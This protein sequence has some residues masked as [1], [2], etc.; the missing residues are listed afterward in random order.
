MFFARAKTWAWRL[1]TGPGEEGSGGNVLPVLLGVGL[2]LRLF[3]PLGRDGLGPMEIYQIVLGR[4]I[5][6]GRAW[7]DDLVFAHHGPVTPVVLRLWTSIG[8]FFASDGGVR[9]VSVLISMVLIAGVYVWLR[10]SAGEWAGRFAA[11]FLCVNDLVVDF[12]RDA[13]LYSLHALLVTG[14]AWLVWRALVRPGAATFVGAA[15]ATCAAILNHLVAA[16]FAA[17]LAV[18]AVLSTGFTRARRLFAAA[19]VLAGIALSSPW[20]ILLLS[21]ARADA[22]LRPN[23]L[24][25]WLELVGL[26]SGGHLLWMAFLPVLLVARWRTILAP[27]VPFDP[28]AA[29]A[30]RIASSSAVSGV[31]LVGAFGILVMPASRTE[32]LLPA[33]PLFAIW[34][35][36]AAGRM[37]EAGR[38]IAAIT[39]VAV[40]FVAAIVTVAGGG[41]HDSGVREKG[42]ARAACLAARAAGVAGPVVVVPSFKQFSVAY[43]WP[44]ATF[45]SADLYVEKG[46]G[47]PASRGGASSEIVVMYWRNLCALP[48][49][50]GECS[51]AR[52]RAAAHARRRFIYA[53]DDVEVWALAP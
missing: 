32:W 17:G 30:G 48:S 42:A 52:D 23:D 16:P 35:G 3:P 39:A 24:G 49:A 50:R 14:A 26:V 34:L 28:C 7:W 27:C 41:A 21:Q 31:F 44:E 38:A 2:F 15:A 19:S 25:W 33:F 47:E 4:R 13:R 51:R 18:G 46:V 1:V 8:P 37:A 12:S 29:A 6:E 36:V 43:Y 45:V 20:A 22:D 53:D 9:L 5:G 10:R 11:A 40:P